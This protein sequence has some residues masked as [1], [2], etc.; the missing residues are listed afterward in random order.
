MF[1]C[2][3]FPVFAGNSPYNFPT[4]ISSRNGNFAELKEL[5]VPLEYIAER[6]ASFAEKIAKKQIEGDSVWKA[7]V[8]RNSEIKV[9][10]K[11]YVR[12][13]LSNFCLM[14]YDLELTGEAQ[15]FRRETDNKH[16]KHFTLTLGQLNFF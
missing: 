4:N 1:F 6:D 5:E 15:F 9:V 2:K 11:H 12:Y 8:D 16:N 13:W 7:V 14:S 3:I 10:I